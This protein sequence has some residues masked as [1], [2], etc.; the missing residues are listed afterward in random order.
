MKF[1]GDVV[2]QENRDEAYPSA[3]AAAA[4]GAAA[5]QSIAQ[6]AAALQLCNR[7]HRQPRRQSTYKL[8]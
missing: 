7:W 5:P 8:L 4:S 3:A 1:G 2:V 6:V